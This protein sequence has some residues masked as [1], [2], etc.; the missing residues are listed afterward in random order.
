MVKVSIGLPVFNGKCLIRNAL[1]SLLAQDFEDFELIICDNASTDGTYE[2]CQQYA[3]RDSRI[4]L[5]RNDTNVGAAKNFAR[6]FELSSAHYFMW[7]A[8]DDMW[9]PQYIGVCLEKLEL[10]PDAVLCCTEIIFINQDGTYRSTWSY[11]NLDTQGMEIVDRVKA[12]I[13]LMGWYAIYGLIRREAVEKLD[14]TIESYG[15]DVVM[16]L[17]LLLQG[18]CLKVPE[19]LFY[20]RLADHP[21]S[22]RD[23]LQAI[24]P[25][26]VGAVTHKPR[27]NMANHLLTV[28]LESEI[29]WR[30]KKQILDSFINVLSFNNPVWFNEMAIE[31]GVAMT[32]A[33]SP[34]KRQRF[35][36]VVLGVHSPL[37]PAPNEKPKNVLVFFPHNPWPAKSGA[38][39]RCLTVL[40]AISNLG[41]AVTLVSSN[42]TTDTPWQTE[43]IEQLQ[44]E[45][46]VKTLLYAGTSEE[47]QQIAMASRTSYSHAEL[48]GWDDMYVP[49]GLR[50]F[51]RSVY[52]HLQPEI[53]LVN[54][55][56]WANLIN[57]PVFKKTYTVMD[58]LDLFTLNLKMG[59][60]L[61]TAIQDPQISAGILSEDFFAIRQLK[62]ENKE[63]EL[64]DRFDCTL[65]VAHTE[66]QLIQMHTQNTQVAC[67]PITSTLVEVKNTYTGAP[68]FVVGPNSFNYQGYLYF[69]YRILPEVLRELPEFRLRV[70]GSPGA[71][72]PPHEGVELLG[73]VPNLR[74]LYT[75]SRFAI[76]PLIGGTGQ[77][78]KI[79]EAMAHGVPVLAL[80]NVAASS[81]IIHGVNGFIA[82]DADEFARY[83][84]ELFR[85]R[86]LCYRL[87]KAT[88]S[89]IAEHFSDQ[90]L[91][92]FFSKILS[93][94]PKKDYAAIVEDQ[95]C[96]YIAFPDW[97][98]NEEK[99]LQSI[100]DL[101]RYWLVTAQGEQATLLLYSD[102]ATLEIANTCL[103]YVLATL[104]MEEQVALCE[105]Q[106]IEVITS[107]APVEWEKLLNQTKA[108]I[109]LD[110]QNNLA[111]LSCG[112]WRLPTLQSVPS[113]VND[114]VFAQ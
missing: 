39:H 29:E 9:A 23:Y 35:V 48:E 88:R 66:A 85:D 15:G 105:Q 101:L 1:D 107:M 104:I 94:I 58:S 8:H 54:Y 52:E 109:A 55:T 32:M 60:A 57:D 44:L 47:S 95:G 25:E 36:E 22:E 13:S 42:L 113:R 106:N 78:V 99:L 110:K 56:L 90:Q 46:G 18:N 92:A 65:A 100:A 31:Q 16:L 2:I 72:F 68:L 27:S 12:L 82:K 97:F 69:I 67:V 50:T 64:M 24:N 108:R 84:I 53:V 83:T 93:V 3:L 40:E 71:S 89:A 45:L 59:K 37:E 28:C 86:A 38:H 103:T 5:Y 43:S 62:T 51:F 79:L 75:D 11:S 81:P 34:K 7:A 73:Y 112:A 76:C 77:Q 20:Y 6:V 30:S 80:H 111:I 96:E 102:Q 63:F 61:A 26:R 4:K 98:Q 41:Y 33:D 19:S 70:V 74:P 17:Q 10:H 21:K 91:K 114:S 87:G 49:E 14:F